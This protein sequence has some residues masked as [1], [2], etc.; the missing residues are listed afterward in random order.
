MPGG[1][2]IVM[3]NLNPIGVWWAFGHLMVLGGLEQL[4]AVGWVGGGTIERFPGDDAD[5]NKQ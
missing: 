5:P 4:G 3:G 1:I 2:G